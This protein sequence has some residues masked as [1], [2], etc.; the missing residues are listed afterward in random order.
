MKNR[1]LLKIFANL[2]IILGIIGI[3]AGILTVLIIG[4][5][6]LFY[7]LNINSPEFEATTLTESIKSDLKQYEIEEEVDSGWVRLEDTLPPVD[8]SLPTGKI[9]NI[10]KIGVNGQIHEGED[11]DSLL[12]KGV[13]R[14]DDFG[15][16][17]D[18]LAIILAA[19]RFGY[20]AWTNDYRN[21]NSFYHLPK[22]TIGDYIEIVWNQ[23][24]YQ[25]EVYKAEENTEITDYS[26]DLILYTCK[27]YN[28]PV[29]I[30]RYANRIN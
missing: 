11:A 3:L 2:N 5:P 27:L 13:W 28:S 24:V 16:P 29:R 26:A 21:T 15:T 30:F 7:F 25:Y 18:D 14:V 8:K 17:E 9:L 22:T 10:P 19:H 1:K 20:V 12:E 4:F 23:R 6:K